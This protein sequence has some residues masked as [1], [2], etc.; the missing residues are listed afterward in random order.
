MRTVKSNPALAG[1]RWLRRAAMVLTICTLAATAEAET[2]NVPPGQGRAIDGD[3]FV[4][5]GERYRVRGIDTPE[6]GQSG[7]DAAQRRLQ[8][9]LDRGVTVDTKARDKYGRTIGN[10]KSREGNDVGR[11]MRQEG[12][13]KR[14]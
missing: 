12:Y 13:S 11:T 7:A 5:R 10:V 4:Y 9:D 14:R 3:T 2:L 1:I 6:R 8:R